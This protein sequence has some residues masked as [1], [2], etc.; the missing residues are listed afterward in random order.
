MVASEIPDWQRA[1]M[2]GLALVGIDPRQEDENGNRNLVYGYQEG[3]ATVALAL[4]H[5]RIALSFTGD[6]PGP[7]E[8]AGWT[9]IRFSVPD[10]EAFASVMNGI[11]SVRRERVKAKLTTPKQTS[12]AEERILNGIM[13]SGLPV[14]VRDL[15]FYDDASGR[16]IT[17]PDF[18]WESVKLAI[19]V[20]G[21][22][23]HHGKNVLDDLAEKEKR[24][25]AKKVTLR[26]EKD[27]DNRRELQSTFG[28]TVIEC[29][30]EKI[31]EKDDYYNSVVA[32]IKK[33]YQRL[34]TDAEARKKYGSSEDALDL[35]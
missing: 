15:A 3:G 6:E 17:T 23:W 24:D 22:Y 33:V 26:N 35:L 12:R 2:Q 16:E 30:A 5:D 7:L 4:V 20:D 25:I 10:L 31:M 9:V 18:S 14:P 32:D 1:F 19:Y 28:W 11:L 34:H 27:A 21:G 13:E 29:S 8:E